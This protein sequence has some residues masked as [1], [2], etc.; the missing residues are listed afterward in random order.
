MYKLLGLIMAIVSMGS[1]HAMDRYTVS[2][3]YRNRGPFYPRPSKNPS[4][5]RIHPKA[6]PVP[7]SVMS[8]KKQAPMPS[9]EEVSLGALAVLRDIEA[10]R[11]DMNLQNA[12]ALYDIAKAR[13][14][15]ALQKEEPRPIFRKTPEKAEQEDK[16]QVLADI[17]KIRNGSITAPR[18]IRTIGFCAQLY[19]LVKE[20]KDA[21]ASL[22]QESEE[23]M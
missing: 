2:D 12:A 16:A 8:K 1:V 13:G 3:P 11:G 20:Y 21:L 23:S 7:L 5:L 22:H 18:E 19:G 6:K 4:V 14:V 15:M 17:E 9:H 10:V